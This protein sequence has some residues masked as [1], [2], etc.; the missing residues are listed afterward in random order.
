MKPFNEIQWKKMCRQLFVIFLVVT[1]LQ[2]ATGCLTQRPY[3]SPVTGQVVI[4]TNGQPVMESVAD[5]NKIAQIIGVVKGVND[6]TAA[7]NPYSVPLSWLLTLAGGVATGISGLVASRKNKQL[8]QTTDI[9]SSV[10]QGVESITSP[11]VSQQVK[12]AIQLRATS[13]GVQPQL[14]KIVQSQT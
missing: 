9:L 12:A 5:T 7:L 6:A 4:G 10:I 13:A 2:L 14:D 3:V 1:V 11:D 8:G